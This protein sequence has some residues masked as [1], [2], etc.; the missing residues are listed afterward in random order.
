MQEVRCG[1]CHRK[2]A[3]AIYTRLNI[4]CPRCGTFNHLSA[5][6]APAERQSSVAGR[7]LVDGITSN[8]V[9]KH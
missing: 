5:T 4:K 1:H 2:L 3:E 8:S 9:P 7:T 6:S